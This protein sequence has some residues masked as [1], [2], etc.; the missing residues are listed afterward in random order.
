ML[1]DYCNRT[2]RKMRG[3]AQKFPRWKRQHSLLLHPQF[4][5]L[6][7][8]YLRG[9]GMKVNSTTKMRTILCKRLVYFLSV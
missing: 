8:H 4:Q 2:S 3:S 6:N 5:E 9:S 1:S 7:E